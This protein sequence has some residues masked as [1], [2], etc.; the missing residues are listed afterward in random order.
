MANWL[1]RNIAGSF[2]A[3]IAASSLV[4][5][6][7]SP[8][9]IPK[10]LTP[11]VVTDMGGSRLHI[12]APPQRVA[13]LAIVLAPYLVING[14]A[15]HVIAA[16]RANLEMLRGN[17][18]GNIFH[19]PEQDQGIGNTYLVTS[20]EEVMRLHPDL[21]FTLKN[22]GATDPMKSANMPGIVE[23]AWGNGRD[24]TYRKIWNLIGAA[25]GKSDRTES[26]LEGYAERRRE[27][28]T[29]LPPQAAVPL[30]VAVLN[31]SNYALLSSKQMWIN[32]KLE[33]VGN[34]NAG[35]D[36]GLNV[37]LDQEDMIR[38]NPDVILYFT[39]YQDDISPD[40]IYAKPGFQSLKAVRNRRV[41]RVP[42]YAFSDTF[43][44]EPILLDWLAEVLYQDAMPRRLRAEYREIY[45][46]VFHYTV[47]DEEIDKAI[48]LKENQQSVGYGR[49]AR[50]ADPEHPAAQGHLCKRM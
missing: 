32:D 17:I 15:S 24:S 37:S 21:V 34:K 33:A 8:K 49:F 48:Y 2:F 44:E 28:L 35:V 43:L 39:G 20:V 46:N 19:L 9:V 36:T 12:D 31:A 26:L 3:L 4:L 42:N 16:S 38:L 40:R 27:V 23:I 5:A 47:S 29:A 22:V 14:D 18:L 50:E 25:T 11:P 1:R 13:I 10:P 45:Q 6:T 30:K 41:Y 7:F